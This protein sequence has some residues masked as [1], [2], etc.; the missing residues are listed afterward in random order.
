MKRHVN[1]KLLACLRYAGVLGH[2]LL[3]PEGRD[4]CLDTLA[5]CNAHL[6]RIGCFPGTRESLGTE[7]GL[8]LRAQGSAGGTSSG[9][10]YLHLFW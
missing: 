1:S 10:A 9:S 3:C 4:S 2:N 8:T 5:P 6:H 7:V